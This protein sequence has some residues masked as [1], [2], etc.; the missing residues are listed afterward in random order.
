MWIMLTKPLQHNA[1]EQPTTETQGSGAAT[2]FF[3]LINADER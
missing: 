3:S 2:H 1:A